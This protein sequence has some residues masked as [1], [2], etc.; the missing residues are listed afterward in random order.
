MFMILAWKIQKRYAI[1]LTLE[2]LIA[3]CFSPTAALD[4]PFGT[5]ATALAC[6]GIMFSKWL[7]LAIVFP[8]VSNGF[9]IAWELSF[10]NTP[11]WGSVWT[12]ALGELAVMV[13]GYIILY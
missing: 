10:Y 12:I 3:N 1:G 7:L 13:A 5:I 2:C 11:F 9:I 4:V 6:L 8:V